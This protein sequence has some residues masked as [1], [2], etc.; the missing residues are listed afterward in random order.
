K[1]HTQF[2]RPD[3]V[4]YTEEVVGA[5]G[6]SGASSICYHIHPP[7]LVERIL[8]PLPYQVA[9]ADEHFLRHRH[10]KGFDVTAGGDWIESRPYLRGSG[11]VRLAL[12]CPTDETGYFYRNASHDELIFVHEGEGTLESIFGTVA[13][14][15]GD[16]VYVPRTVTHRWTFTGETAPRL[17][18]IEAN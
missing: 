1:R 6:F 8:Q 10:L 9:Y 11:A 17:L 5:E 18:V 13:F 15:Q 4:L 14:T 7:T 12:A 3:G 16:Y 2:R